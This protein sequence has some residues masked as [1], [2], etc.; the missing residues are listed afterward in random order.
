MD[1]ISVFAADDNEDV[2][3]MIGEIISKEQDLVLVG[4]A[5]DGL[6][7]VEAIKKLKPEVVL[8]DVIMPKLDGLGV[9]QRLSGEKN[10]IGQ[11]DFIMLSA[12]GKDNITEDAFNF[13]AEY[14]ML[15]PFDIHAL[16]QKI[17]DCHERRLQKQ[18]K[19]TNRTEIKHTSAGLG[20]PKN[21]LPNQQKENISDHDLELEITKII[22]EIGVPAHIKGYQ[23]IRDGIL[24][25][26]RDREMIN[27]ITKILYP[28][29]SKK[30]ATTSS[31]VERAIR[32]SI[33]VA[34]NRGNPDVIEEYFGYTVSDGKG[35][36]TNSEFIALIADKLRLSYGIL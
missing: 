16:V 12:I 10:L 15:K 1:K 8:L 25:S 34:W 26:I 7:A 24:M 5:T 3:E 19:Q 29:I 6:D 33:E 20:L 13:G 14:Y 17:K 2:L 32:H 35:K 9:L 4:T 27:S 28:T 18:L 11:T 31:R 23:Y 30:Y 36:P 22:H 21:N